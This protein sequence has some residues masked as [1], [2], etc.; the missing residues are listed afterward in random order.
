MDLRHWLIGLIF[1]H[2]APLFA[3][4]D[5]PKNWS[6]NGYV[7]QLHSVFK[8]DGFDTYFMDQLIHNRLNFKWYPS[9][10]FS[11]IAEARNRIFYGDLVKL[12]PDYA[13]Q[14]ELANNDYLDMSFHLVNKPDWVINSTVDRFFLQFNQGNVEARVGRQRIN[15][16]ISTVWNPNDLFNAFAF[17]DFDY[18]ER[19]GSDGLRIKYYTG[20]AGSIEIAS[21]AARSWGKRVIAGLFKFNAA[22]YDFQILTGVANRDLVLGGGWAGNIKNSGFK[23][24]WSYFTPLNEDDD[25][26]SIA[27]TTAFDH[28]FSNSLYINLGYLYNSNGKT[29]GSLAELFS[30]ELSAKNLYPFRHAIF[31]SG[32]YPVTPLINANLAII[33]S[34][35]RSHPLFLNPTFTLSIAQNWDLD[36]VGQV[37]FSKTAAFRNAVTAAFLRTKFSF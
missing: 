1:I 31:V 2:T 3:Q 28:S 20:V 30:F 13:A 9:D 19:P 7:K 26:P 11:L 17:T 6:L 10:Q 32:G 25:D 14:I 33:Y 27:L 16:G 35:V 8:I 15:W 24:E 23:G 34:P 5:K 29:S 21:N 4:E 37:A 12:T 22:Q 36:L 18:E